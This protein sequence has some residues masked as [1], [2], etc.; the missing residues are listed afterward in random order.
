MQKRDDKFKKKTQGGFYSEFKKVN[1]RGK[2]SKDLKLMIV[3]LQNN[4]VHQLTRIKKLKAVIELY[5]E[6]D[7]TK[8]VTTQKAKL[9]RYTTEKVNLKR[10]LTSCEN[11]L[12]L[13]VAEIKA[14]ELKLKEQVRLTTK[15]KKDLDKKSEQVKELSY[16]KRKKVEV[17]KP[18]TK[19]EKYLENLSKRLTEK[20]Y[21]ISELQ[22]FNQTNKT[23]N[24]L[25]NKNLTIEEL[26]TIIQAEVKGNF[27]KSE[28][29]LSYRS[30]QSLEGKGFI[31]SS[32]GLNNSNKYWFISLNGKELL[33]N[34]KNYISFS[35]GLI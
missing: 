8:K 10:K 9:E 11:S 15:L 5:K 27:K 4:V 20:Q 18:K 31:Q 12:S 24:F 7:T 14:I 33:K 25:K 30:L 34:Y 23:A 26:N 19:E 35:K 28:V 29:T 16:R 21:K 22:L 3:D 13:K 2:S 1:P 6:R 17:E 32:F